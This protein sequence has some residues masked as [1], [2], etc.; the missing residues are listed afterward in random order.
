M[1]RINAEFGTSV[2][3]R[4]AGSDCFDQ[5]PERSAVWRCRQSTFIARL[6]GWQ[7]PCHGWIVVAPSATEAEGVDAEFAK[8][9]A[10]FIDQYRP[11]LEA[12]AK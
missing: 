3:Y 2:G 6:I 1:K 5:R 10:D 8:Q 12:L 4:T 11:A 7:N 9:V